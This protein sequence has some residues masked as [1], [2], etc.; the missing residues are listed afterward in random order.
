VRVLVR[1]ATPADLDTVGRLTYDAYAHDAP[2]HDGYAP[3]LL[4]AA[5]RSREAVLLVA[6]EDGQVVG[7]ATY[8]PDGGPLAELSSAPGD[9]EFR[10]LAV[11][12][13]ARGRGVAETLVRA[14]IE[15]ARTAGKQRMVLSS[16]RHMLAAHRLYERL[17]FVRAPELD[18]SPIPEINLV[19]YV[20]PL[21]PTSE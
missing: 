16:S 5:G 21:L 20:L 7:T 9:A 10:M 13:A 17:G 1:E 18:W 8:V 3:E 2:V 19:A 12:P 14:M 11:D 15:R 4:D 6:E